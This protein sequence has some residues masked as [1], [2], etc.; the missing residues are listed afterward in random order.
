MQISESRK[1]DQGKMRW[2]L[3][4][5]GPLENVV[6]VLNIGAAKYG[7]GNWQNL[8]DFKDR[9]LDAAMRHIVA[10]RRGE[11]LD[12]DSGLPSLA[13]AVCCLLFLMWN[14]DRD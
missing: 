6:A 11:K 8:D 12:R 1:D 5:L 4:P 2:S 14:D 9:Y 3:L 10:W 13:H 7:A